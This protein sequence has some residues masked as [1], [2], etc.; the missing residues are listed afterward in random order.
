VKDSTDEFFA[1]RSK[2]YL[3]IEIDSP[4]IATAQALLILSSHEAAHARESR[5]WIY[6]G[7]AVQIMTDLGLHLNLEKEYS[8]L[9]ARD[10]TEID[11]VSI[12]RRNLFWSTNTIDTLWSAHC[13]RPSLMKNLIHNVRDPLPSPTYRW[14]YYT[15]EYST[16]RFPPGVD[17]AAAAHV[18]V[19]L[20]SLMKI[21]AR[22]SEVLYSGVP[23]VSNDIELFVSQAESD[24]QQWFTSL[25]ANLQV[26]TAGS[27]SFYLPPVLE[28]HLAYQECIILLH[29]PLITPEDLASDTRA[30]SPFGKCVKSAIEICK[31]LVLF[32]KMYGLRRPH[33]HMVHVTMTA[34]LIHIFQLCIASEN[35]SKDAAQ[36]NFL[37]CIQALGEMGQTYKS[38]SRA[39][40]VVTSLRQSWQDDIFA[41]DRFKRARLH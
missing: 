30:A 7:M 37:T 20:A 26:D 29:R 3:D 24:F 41:G 22:V 10:V 6:S 1:F 36:R 27:V 33:H 18:H 11:D 25:P 39:L 13:G 2:V 38:A 28:L 8:R 23:D 34:A 12:L 19:H 16:V 32:R 21:L 14:E 5:G 40:D 4:T 17:F 9:E 15:D 31:I 35:E